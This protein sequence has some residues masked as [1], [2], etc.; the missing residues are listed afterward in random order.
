MQLLLPSSAGRRGGRWRNH[1]QMIE[2][3]AVYNNQLYMLGLGDIK[4]ID[5]HVCAGS[6][7]LRTI[8][9]ALPQ[10]TDLS[11]EISE[12]F[13]VRGRSGLLIMWSGRV[14]GVGARERRR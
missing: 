1:R 8:R 10:H 5:A 4:T 6:S 9:S 12:P 11:L 13:P 2:A 3:I 7:L 14:G